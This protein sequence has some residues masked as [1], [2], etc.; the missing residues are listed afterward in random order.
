MVLADRRRGPS[1]S[2][3]GSAIAATAALVLG[4]MSILSIANYWLVGMEFFLPLGDVVNIGLLFAPPVLGLGAVV[5][6][7]V[8]IARG[9]R[10]QGAAVA[11]II[12]G[13]FTIIWT[14]RFWQRFV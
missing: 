1:H 13:F 3:R 10:R 14:A 4:V 8:S 9:E 6:G 11:G 12:V 2:G 5:L 7:V